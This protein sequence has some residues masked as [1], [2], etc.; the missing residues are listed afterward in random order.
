MSK[1]KNSSFEK[2]YTWHP[3]IENVCIE[4]KIMDCLTEFTNGGSV[5]VEAHGGTTPGDLADRREKLYDERTRTQVWPDV[6]ITINNF[7]GLATKSG[8]GCPWEKLPGYQES[9]GRLF[10]LHKKSAPHTILIPG[11]S[12]RIWSIGGRDR[13]GAL[14]V[15]GVTSGSN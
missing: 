5:K 6:Q 10:A 1:N 3:F 15:F 8:K 12:A 7:N 13:Y 2:A 9:V 14:E 4:Q 11:G